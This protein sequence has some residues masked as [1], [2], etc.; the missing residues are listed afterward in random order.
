MVK[1]N[2]SF[3]YHSISQMFNLPAGQSF[4]FA[5]VEGPTP[6]VDFCKSYENKA[7]KELMNDYFIDNPDASD[8]A[9]FATRSPVSTP[10]SLAGIVP[11]ANSTAI[12]SFYTHR[13][14]GSPTWFTMSVFYTDSL[15]D[16]FATNAIPDWFVV[17]EIGE[18]KA[19]Q[20]SKTPLTE[21]TGLTLAD[22]LLDFN[23]LIEG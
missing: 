15:Y 4:V 2:A 14:D 17:G 13:H 3:V 5:L 1:F 23:Q 10:S 20:L 6:S 8:I 16:A 9:T 21:Y 7:I 18:G 11:A 12:R 22:I 19:L